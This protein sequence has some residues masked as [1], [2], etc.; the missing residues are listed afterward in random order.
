MLIQT[1]NYDS[2]WLVLFLPV[3]NLIWEFSCPFAKE[4]FGL[5]LLDMLF[6]YTLIT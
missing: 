1:I 6:L 2:S 5:L 3:I 4:L